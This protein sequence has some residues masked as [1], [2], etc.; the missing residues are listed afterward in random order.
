MQ[1]NTI[2]LPDLNTAYIFKF[3]KMT[4][5]EVEHLMLKTSANFEFYIPYETSDVKYVVGAVYSVEEL[6]NI[7]RYLK[8]NSRELLSATLEELNNHEAMLGVECS[9]M[10][11]VYRTVPTL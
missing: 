4:V 10:K 1:Q 2:Q 11:N 9:Y 5:Q 6:D 3:E 7:K 8:S